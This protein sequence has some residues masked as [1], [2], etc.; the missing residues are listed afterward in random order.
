M[1]THT[2]P[3]GQTPPI[4][5]GDLFARQQTITGLRAL[6]DFLEANPAVPVDEYGETYHVFAHDN[7]A[8][9]VAQVDQT[10]ALLGAEVTDDRPTGGHYTATK[11]FGRITY[12]IVHI[13]KR[14]KREALARNSY[15]H[16]IILDTNQDG[17]DNDEQAA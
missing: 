7:D 4:V 9:A 15:R 3:T 10:A 17:A 16:N 13:P 6:A 1:T 12:R 14:N 11:R 2:N 5:P 8:S